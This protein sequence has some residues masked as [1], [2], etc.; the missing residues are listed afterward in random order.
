YGVEIEIARGIR[1][2]D[3]HEISIGV[4]RVVGIGIV[5][6]VGKASQGAVGHRIISIAGAIG[7]IIRISGGSC[8]QGRTGIAAGAESDIYY[9]I[10]KT[11]ALLRPAEGDDTQ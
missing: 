9:R 6:G 8:P 3:Q 1:G 2:I 7:A 4:A 10:A 11:G 5:P